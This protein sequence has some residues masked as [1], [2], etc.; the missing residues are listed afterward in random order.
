MQRSA[1]TFSSMVVV[2]WSVWR[3]PRSLVWST[4]LVVVA[5]VSPLFPNPEVG[6]L[7]A[8]LK[9]RVS[10][11]SS[12]LAAIR[13]VVRPA[14]RSGIATSHSYVDAAQ[15]THRLKNRCDLVK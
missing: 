6:A 12:M 15:I 9:Q 8:R 5:H 1:T 11:V 2:P 14:D 4:I 10:D 13:R 7:G 3:G